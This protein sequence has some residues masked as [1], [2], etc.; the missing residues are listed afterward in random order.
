MADLEVPSLFSLLWD[1]HKLLQQKVK[2]QKQRQV[3]E[4]AHVP[5]L[6]PVTEEALGDRS[7]FRLHPR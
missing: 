7:F 5:L 4:A 3:P 2:N 6:C 1:I